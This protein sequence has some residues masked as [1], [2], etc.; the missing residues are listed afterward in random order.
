MDK[1]GFCIG[2]GRAH[3]V[4]ILDLIKPLYMTDPDNQDYII[5]VECVS[6]GS[7]IIPLLIIISSARVLHK[8]S[9]NN[10]DGDT[11]FTTSKTSYSNNDIALDWL[12]HFI[13]HT[14]RKRR[15]ARLLLIIDGFGLH[16]TIPFF[17]KAEANQILL[18][19]L[20]AHSIHFTQPLDIGVF[21]PFKH[22]HTE[23][24]NNAIRLSNTQFSKLE[25][26]ATFQTM[27]D[28][29][30]KLSTIYYA[31]KITGIIPFNLEA[32]LE[33]IREKQA[34]LQAVTSF[35]IFSPEPLSLNQRTPQ[36][37][38][39]IVKYREK[40]QKA[41]IRGEPNAIIALVQLERF[42]QKSIANA[43]KLQLVDQ[44][45]KAIQEATTAHEKQASLGDT[46]ASKAGV[47]KASQCKELSSKRKK[48]EKEQTQKKKEKEEKKAEITRVQEAKRAWI[49][50]KNQANP[51]SQVRN[52]S[53]S[54]LGQIAFLLNIPLMEEYYVSYTWNLKL[55]KSHG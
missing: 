35:F 16:M 25:F 55:C 43:F 46:V 14:A 50:R 18:F 38:N 44:D 1:T 24:I 2:C 52:L 12:D 47:I 39:S 32:V 21:Q 37:P 48:K 4:V 36:S 5:S 9:K 29:T 31:F 7:A 8:W 27:R 3:Y 10:L 40:L 45:L 33:G 30:F 15:G 34:R 26:L 13:A 54:Q 23:A 42:I 51:R 22:Y 53:T 11:L 17:E 41:L 20:P 28:Q 19:Q 6:S 49:Q